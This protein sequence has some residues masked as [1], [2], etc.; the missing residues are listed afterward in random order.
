MRKLIYVLCSLIYVSLS[1]RAQTYD[2]RLAYAI[3]NSEWFALDSI[4][5]SAPKD[6]ISPFMEIFSRCMI[7][8][9][10]NRPDVSI[11]AF[12][13]LL[14]TQSENLDL[15]NLLNS[16]VMFAMDLS[17]T[18]DNATAASM[19]NS[20]L[21]ATR[22]YLDTAAISGI[23]KYI[24]KYTA[25]SSYK[26]YGIDFD[27]QSC[28]AI[29]FKFVPVGPAKH[30]SLLMHLEQCSINDIEA[31]ITFD[32][33]AGVN[34]ISDSLAQE[35]GL[36]PLDA[37][38]KVG[39][40]AIQSGR[41]AIAKKLKLGNIT[42]TD[43]P[44]T[45]ITITANNKEA[46]QYMD[47]FDIILG[48]ELMLQLKDVTLDFANRQIDIPAKAPE[49][50]NEPSNMCFSSQMNLMTRGKIHNNPMLINLD[51]GDASYGSL[52]KTFFENNKDFINSHATLDS[53][54]DAGIGGVLVTPCYHVPDLEVQIGGSSVTVPQMTVRITPEIRPGADYDCN[55]GIKSL[56]QFGKL[57]FNMVDFTITTYP[58]QNAIITKH[59]LPAEYPAPA[60]TIYKEEETTPLQAIG[61]IATEVARELISHR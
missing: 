9:R 49:L 37:I 39:G 41:C 31:D 32:T 13:E 52:N 12:A 29:P 55:L 26:P 48:S 6:S 28:G 27:N 30:N 53:I 57:R 7:G 47:C 45:V 58:T 2:E 4:Y 18:G 46:D 22:Q 36:I 24:N 51:T 17:R 14:N 40:V 43:V 20:I 34:I 42:I 35:Y 3:N 59:G 61:I 19:L 16:S 1:G 21:D 25:L 23:Q 54:R 10:L 56:M 8:N 33:G 50:S 5:R 38:E 11:P 60:L 44:F 15:G